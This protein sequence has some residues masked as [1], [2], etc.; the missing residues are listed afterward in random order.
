MSDAKLELVAINNER[1]QLALVDA[2]ARQSLL[3]EV[4]EHIDNFTPDI[5]T[6]TGRKA[7]ASIAYKVAQTKTTIDAVGKDLVADAKAKIKVVDGARKEIRDTLDGLR[8][9]VREPLTKYEQRIEDEKR[10]IAG[11]E[12]TKDLTDI[13]TIMET[14]E[15]F[16]GETHKNTIEFMDVSLQPYAEQV[17]AAAI[18]TLQSNLAKAKEAEAEAKRIE[19]ERAELDRLRKAEADRKAAE[20]RAEL[21]RKAAERAT[22]EAAAAAQRAIDDANRK[23]QEAEQRAAMAEAQA[24]AR[25]EAERQQQAAQEAKRAADQIHRNNIMRAAYMDIR[26]MIR[27]APQDPSK[28]AEMVVREIAAG[29]VANVKMEW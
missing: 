17:K 1:I 13:Q 15:M 9:S 2:E 19:E 3:A 25:A 8:D 18:A 27:D 28:Q 4:Q 26:R 22:A 6:V 14:L 16:C 12:A 10:I 5:T 24:K 29:N 7:I 20:E 21:E 11:W 23:V